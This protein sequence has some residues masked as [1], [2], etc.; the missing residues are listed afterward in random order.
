MSTTF[1]TFAVTVRPRDGITDDHI[2]LFTAFVKKHCTYY[3]IITEKT[4]SQRHIHSALFFRIPKTRS[5]VATYLTRLFKHFD[6]QEKADLQ[7]GL[8]ILYSNDFILKYMD[9]DD[10][11]VVIE[12]NL[13][14]VSSLE[15]F[16]PPLPNPTPLA[17]VRRLAY[18]SEMNQYETL[19]RLHVPP[20][21]EINTGTVRDFLFNM[22]YN[23]RTIGLMDD[24]KIIFM[25]KSFTR[26]MNRTSY[27]PD[28]FLPPFVSEEGPGIHDTRSN[29]TY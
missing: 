13:P 20:H 9:K 3:Y 17:E 14:E 11:T 29:P 6:S 21:V 22:M 26:W 7:R 15:A 2:A 19:W 12:R 1:T 10:D 16:Y 28:S 27:C 8:K 24:K 4:G 5:N 18:H 25:S 23:V